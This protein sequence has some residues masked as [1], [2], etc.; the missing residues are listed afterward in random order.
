MPPSLAGTGKS[1]L[2]RE[3]IAALRK[4]YRD[5]TAV[6]VTASTGIAGASLTPFASSR[7]PN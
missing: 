6:G 5:P 7:N 2:L 1:V 4:K 3:L